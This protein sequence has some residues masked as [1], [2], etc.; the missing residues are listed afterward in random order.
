MAET[1]EELTEALGKYTVWCD[2]WRME[3]GAKKCG[4]M[5][6]HDPSA[7]EQLKGATWKLQGQSIPVVDQYKYLGLQIGCS[8]SIRAMVG[9]RQTIGNTRLAA[10]GPVLSNRRVPCEIKAKAVSSILLPG[11]TYGSAAY[12]LTQK[13]TYAKL[14]SVLRK[15]ARMVVMMGGQSTL[16][17][18]A[19]LLA[20]L[21]ITPI[22]AIV[23]AEK[24]RAVRKWPHSKT[25]INLDS[26]NSCINRHEKAVCMV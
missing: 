13:H 22:R 1:Q 23:G 19:C 10:M 25:W 9:G 17:S 16:T 8:I 15:A 4:V 18:E 2:K 12:G 3:A 5:C 11:L 14:E 6:L 21:G 20:E 7:H 24:A 26:S